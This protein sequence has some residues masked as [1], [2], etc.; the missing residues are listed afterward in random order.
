MVKLAEPGNR[1]RTDG[2]AQA[3]KPPAGKPLLRRMRENKSFYV[4]VSPFF[5]LFAAFGAFPILAAFYLGFTR[6]DGLT[7]P[8]FVGFEN[9]VRIFRDPLFPKVLYNTVY[10]WLGSTVITLGLAFVLAYLINEYVLVGQT[11]LRMVFLVPLLVA[12]AVAAIVMSVLFSTNAGLVNAAWS[13]LADRRVTFDWF[14]SPYW[15]KPMVVLMIVWR[16]TGFHLIIFLA[17]L[18]SI[19][20]ELYDAARVDGAK[21]TQVFFRITVPL[22]IPIIFFSAISATVGGFQLFDE[23][24]V[25]TG[26][27]GGTEQS[28]Q[29]LGTYLYQTAFQEFRFGLASALSWVMFGLIAVFALINA[30]LL[31]R[32]T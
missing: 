6:W 5:L 3:S 2:A 23:P 20:R 22:M 29:V 25:L 27:T 24:Y 18:Q 13:F 15:I 10:V 30:R 11:A 19:P 32:R 16:Y 8:E 31:R 7:A 9:Y 1:P 14:A 21:G 26:G 17:G 28:G 12:P 4:S